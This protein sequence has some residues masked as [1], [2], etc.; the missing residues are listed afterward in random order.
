MHKYGE[1]ILDSAAATGN[2]VVLSHTGDY[3][4]WC[5]ENEADSLM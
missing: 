2:S 3:S 5:L 4:C 1:H